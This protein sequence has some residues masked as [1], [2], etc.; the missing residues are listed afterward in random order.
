MLLFLYIIAGQCE[1]CIEG[2]WLCV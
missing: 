2:S 1:D